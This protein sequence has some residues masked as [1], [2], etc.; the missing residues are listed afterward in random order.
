MSLFEQIG[1]QRAVKPL[2]FKGLRHFTFL[3]EHAMIT[4]K[5]TYSDLEGRRMIFTEYAQ[6]LMEIRKA[7]AEA[8]Q[9]GWFG[10]G[11]QGIGSGWPDGMPYRTN[12]PEAALLQREDLNEILDRIEKLYSEL[13]RITEEMKGANNDEEIFR[14]Y[15]K[16]G[17]NPSESSASRQGIRHCDPEG[18]FMFSQRADQRSAASSRAW[19]DR[20]SGC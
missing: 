5:G 20:D 18:A 4:S 16:L 15:E 17:K 19:R 9:F 3:P 7:E 14:K 2:I 8:E 1:T 12:E 6:I 11:P 10:N 13:N